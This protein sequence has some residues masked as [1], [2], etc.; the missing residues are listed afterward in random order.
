MYS[1]KESFRALKNVFFATLPDSFYSPKSTSVL[2]LALSARPVAGCV[3][4]SGV[5]KKAPSIATNVND[6]A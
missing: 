4:D 2:A 5:W 1:F 6:G 3:L